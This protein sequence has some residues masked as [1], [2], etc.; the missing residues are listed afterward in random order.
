M[1]WIITNA[2]NPGD[3]A[4]TSTYLLKA[5]ENAGYRCS[6]WDGK[7]VI[8]KKKDYIIFDECKI[9]AIYILKGYK[10]IIVWVQGVV[11]EEA[12]MKGYPKYRYIAHSI[13]EYISLRKAKYI[14]VCSKTMKKHYETKYKL[15][16]SSKV[17]IMPCFNE[18]DIDKSSFGIQKKY[19]ENTFLYV[20]TLSAWQC[21]EETLQIY[22]EIEKEKEKTCLYVYTPNQDEARMALAKYE[23]QNY[24]VDYL[25]A[26]KL[27]EKI[28]MVKYGFVLRKRNIVNQV[29]TPTKLSNYIAH[30][31]IPIYSDCLQSFNDYQQKS[32]GYAVIC[33]VENKEEGIKNILENMEGNID[34][35]SIEKW[36]KRTFSTYYN[37]NKYIK[38]IGEFLKNI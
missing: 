29:A 9:A 32:S 14:F 27:G 2:K 31:I 18:I 34:S 17:F 12:I 37:Q 35:L 33:N 22:K 30:G 25:P 4:V 11:P 26:D 13:L 23:I 16:I 24:Q 19:K 15:D 6:P 5:L 20:G 38:D 8:D 3:V 7:S 10:N 1:I 36:C 21:F 28:K